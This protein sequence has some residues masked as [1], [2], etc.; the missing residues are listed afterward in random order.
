MFEF[1]ARN[2][3]ARRIGYPYFGRIVTDDFFVFPKYLVC[4]Q[5]SKPF[6]IQ[7]HPNFYRIKCER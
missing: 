5:W 1:Y 4:K 2:Q 6:T 3:I 7:P